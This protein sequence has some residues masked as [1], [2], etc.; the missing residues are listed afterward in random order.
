MRILVIGSGG[1]EHALLHAMHG[2]ELT[3]A[4]GNAG[5][6]GLATVRSV[7]VASPEAIVA[8][9]RDIEAELVVIGPEVPLVAGAADALIEA[10]IPVFGPTQAAA[11]LEGSKA[12]AKDVM[13]AAGV[14]TASASRVEAAEDIE[15]ALDKFGP[16]YV[17]K[18]DGL[19]GGKGVVVTLSLI[20][21]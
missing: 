6:S 4:P 19:A 2:H 20:H 16:R 8:L 3:V 15:A 11:Q 17:V 10:G 7:D 18:D 5:M 1:R 21:I 9:A 13:A 14:L 12:F